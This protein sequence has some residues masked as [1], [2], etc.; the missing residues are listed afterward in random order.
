MRFKI[1]KRENPNIN[2]YIKEEIDVAY[3]FTEKAYKEF[4]DFIKSIVLF[5]SKSK[6]TDSGDKSDIDILIIIDDTAIY[7]TDEVIQTYR[8]IIEKISSQTSDKLHITTL[9]FTHFWDYSRVGD[10]IAINMLRDGVPLLDTGFFEPLQIL[11]KQGKIRPTPESVWTYLGRASP[12]LYNSKWHI[13]QATLD[14]YWAVI[15]AAHAALMDC[16][17]IPPSPA[18]VSDLM[19]EKLVKPNLLNKRYVS[20][21]RNFYKLSRMIIHREIREIKGEEYDRYI[22]D[23]TD[24][25]ETMRKLILR[26]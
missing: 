7:L 5:G 19:E 26:K 17:E 21:M 12:T 16:G 15:D 10:P 25:V 23:A 4:G 24:F 9:Q 6:K 18:R 22:A 2:K 13:L 3:A 1:E 11:L 14:L 20:I 8:V